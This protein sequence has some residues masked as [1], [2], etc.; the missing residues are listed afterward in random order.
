M[1][2]QMIKPDIWHF[3]AAKVAQK[4]GRSVYFCLRELDRRDEGVESYQ[5]G[6]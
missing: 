4:T 5:L 6:G 3:S 1:C 2:P